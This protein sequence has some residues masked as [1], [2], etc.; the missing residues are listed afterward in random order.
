MA[1]LSVKI[2]PTGAQS[3]GR[4][5][6]RVI[7]DIGGAAE[8]TEKKVD[9][10]TRSSESNFRKMTR[11]VNLAEMSMRSLTRAAG[12]LG[13]AV[14]TAMSVRSVVGFKDAVAEV[15][16]LVDT[17]TFN[18]AKLEKGATA[19][20]RAFG[21]LTGQARA[22][23][24]IISAG[25]SSAAE[26]TRTLDAANRLAVGGVTS[27][28]VAAD[29]LTSILNAY[30]SKVESAT[31]VSDA[32]FVAMRAGKT[33]IEE[34]SSTLGRVA[35]LAA[36]TGVGFDE[37]VASIAA[38]T[39]GGISTA[40][41]VTG[42]RAILA[43][44]AKPTSEASKLAKQLGIDFTAAGLASKGFAGFLEDLV[45][46][47]GGNTAVLAQLFGGVEALVPAMALAGQAGEDF[48]DVLG[49]MENKAGQT[50]IA[51]NKMANS[52]GFQAGR[53][54]SAL[55]AE[56]LGVGGTMTGTLVPAIKAVADNMGLIVNAVVIF[57][58]GHLAAAL[59][60]VIA[61]FATMTA[62]MGAA[63]VAART[64]S[65][66]M[67]FVGGPIGIAVTA[68]AGGYLLLR[69]NVSAAAQATADAEFAYRQNEGALNNAKAASEGYTMALR[70]QIAMQVEAAKSAMILANAEFEAANARRVGFLRL[71]GLNSDILQHF[72]DQAASEADALTKAYVNLGKQLQTVDGNLKKV[73]TSTGGASVSI[74]DLDEKTKN[75]AKAAK[76]A[77]RE[78]ERFKDTADGLV[79][80]FFP[81]EAAEARIKELMSLLDKYGD[82]LT[83]I[84]RKAVD[85]E[86]DALRK[87][88][89]QADE[90][91]KQIEQTLGDALGD[92]FTKPAADAKDF[93]RNLAR[94][95][96]QIGSQNIKN[97]F[98]GTPTAANDN[99]TS[100][101]GLF[102]GLFK[103]ISSATQT[104]AEA[105]TAKGSVT[106][107]S[108]IFG[109]GG[110]I[111][112]GGTASAVLGG[113][114]I[115]Y[116]TGGGTAG[117]VMGGIGGALSGLAATGGNP[118][119]ALAGGL[120]G[121]VGSLFGGSNN[122]QRQQA[123]AQFD[124]QRE[125]II[126]LI[127]VGR[128]R[129][130]G[131]A[132]QQVREYKSQTDPAIELAKKAG[133]DA[134]VRQLRKATAAFTQR[135]RKE[136]LGG[137]E[138]TIDALRSGLGDNSPFVVAR[139][140]ML[141]LRDSLQGVI[142]DAKE[143]KRAGETQSDVAKRTRQARSAAQQ[144]ALSLLHGAREM[145]EMEAA[146]AN[147][148]G[149]ASGL[150]KTLMDLGMS[151][152]EA[153]KAISKRLRSALDDLRDEYRGDVRSSI[154]DL[155]GRG[156]LNDIADAQ[157]KYNERLKD[158]EA[159]GLSGAGAFKE[160]QL[161]LANI[162][163]NSNLTD[164]QIDALSKRFPAL[165]KALK[166]LSDVTVSVDLQQFWDRIFT[167]RIDTSTLKGQ[168]AVFNRA[169][170]AEYEALKESGASKHA[171]AVLENTL[172]A[173]RKA[174]IRQYR[175]QQVQDARQDLL[176]AY[177]A[178]RSELEDTAS[179]LENF[180]DQVKAFRDDLKLDS[181]LST[182]SASERLAEAQQQYSSTFQAAMRG[183]ETAMSSLTSAAQAYLEEA[184]SYY[185]SSP[186]YATIF[187][188]VTSSLDTVQA[189]ATRQLTSTERQ[190]DALERQV[191]K[192]IDI[193]DGVMSVDAAIR[194]LNRYM[195]AFISSGGDRGSLEGFARGGYTGDG[196]SNVVAG[197]VHRG[198]YV[199]DQAATARYRPYLEQMDSGTFGPR[200]DNNSRNDAKLAQAII[201][202]SAQQVEVMREELRSVRAELNR[203][204]NETRIAANRKQRKANG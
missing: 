14:G 68:L 101:G 146:V 63:A 100:S 172:N 140:N 31:A 128:G 178:E 85:K 168:L 121:V 42:V 145:T 96:A 131:T 15:S 87:V 82:K 147:A 119:G 27:V 90:T 2:D 98:S 78:F 29:G 80:K 58:A 43:A 67:A 5:V 135:V 173:E 59:A 34:L 160:L 44:V 141:D 163:R 57:T 11:S 118:L 122:K 9:R 35:P 195:S 167:A 179:T 148:R 45:Q 161:S 132:T 37:L 113:A 130:V 197:V 107:L 72:E 192:L 177:N 70:N 112:S 84:Q 52:P 199:M 129:G 6:R 17:T 201:T 188:Q 198:E 117:T 154:N 89:D 41:S 139:K 13:A 71:T 183:D 19:Q 106:G 151:S 10:L 81:K 116:Q 99:V 174:L 66:A 21:D 33:T 134:M 196:P 55:Q 170:K 202:S 108:A 152:T 22:Y 53:V 12:A 104:G 123:K 94:S 155:S 76:E 30:G 184:K 97:L 38:L 18:M 150:K 120:A 75:A 32:L 149:T 28:A 157:E 16:T 203:L 175:E 182:L 60:T 49:Q 180:I 111:L 74:G 73:A 3:G 95:F 115:G 40:E 8:T 138:S 88:G 102:S 92:L 204:T 193:D 46:K 185:A 93:F 69:D 159:L 156:Y 153:S 162:I 136:F 143:F 47:T 103:T 62:T 166:D 26:A 200:N 176:N 91:A 65:A 20:G 77:A 109:K 64:L 124:A 79:E 83:E 137:F 190:I 110:G 165:R 51:F 187:E 23:Y 186:Q 1:T 125:N 144:Y 7:I 36:Q 61:R 158:A 142:S 105:G 181:N 126:S 133:N 48:S 164:K 171:L 56:V 127:D 39:K 114:G 24:Q 54:W 50:E 191:S 194:Q 4:V 25:A 189:S 86:I 169:A